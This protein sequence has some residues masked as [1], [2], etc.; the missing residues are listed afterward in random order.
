VSVRPYRGSFEPVGVVHGV[1][2]DI[3]PLAAQ[4]RPV[5]SRG[6]RVKH[7]SRMLDRPPRPVGAVN[8]LILAAQ[9]FALIPQPPGNA[10]AR[11]M[12]TT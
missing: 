9:L 1:T 7:D 4:A 5:C 10:H 12:S 2:L 11:S 8:V 6:H 3:E